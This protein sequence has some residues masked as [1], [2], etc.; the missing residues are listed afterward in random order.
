MFVMLFGG[1]LS[2]G[3][4]G[5]LG[6]LTLAVGMGLVASLFYCVKRYVND[7]GN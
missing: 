2:R 3:S 5:E 6:G 4:L 1:W 7:V